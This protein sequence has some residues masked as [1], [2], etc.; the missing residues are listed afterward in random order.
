MVEKLVVSLNSS[1]WNHDMQLHLLVEIR[2][3]VIQPRRRDRML[4][5]LNDNAKCERKHT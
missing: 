3:D 2:E 5:V 4:G 1:L